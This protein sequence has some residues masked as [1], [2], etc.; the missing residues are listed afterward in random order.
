MG[1]LRPSG[2]GLH[3]TREAA[4][5]P[6]AAAGRSPA[7]RRRSDQPGAGRGV[8]FGSGAQ[9]GSTGAERYEAAPGRVQRW[10][11]RSGGAWWPRDR[12]PSGPAGL[13]GYVSAAGLIGY[14]SGPAGLTGYVPRGLA[15]L[16]G[17]AGLTG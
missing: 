9:P 8:S 13:I 5:R 10:S 6:F 1:S 7:E 16:T 17:Y 3:R 15:G 12:R 2:G 11:R 14:V 4:S